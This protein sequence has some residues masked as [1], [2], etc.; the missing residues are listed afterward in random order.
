[1]STTLKI[2]FTL[3]S[4]KQEIRRF[5]TNEKEILPALI[6]FLDSTYSKFYVPPLRF[7][8]QYDD[9][10]DLLTVSSEMELQE[11]LAL[12][13]AQ[14]GGSVWKLLCRF[15]DAP[16][17]TVGSTIGS[18]RLSELSGMSTP[19]V[20]TILA[21]STE[22]PPSPSQMVGIQRED[23]GVSVK[24]EDKP[25]ES[26]SDSEDEYV[27]IEDDAPPS[28]GTPPVMVP[29]PVAS[30]SVQ[31]ATTEVVSTPTD[32][33]TSTEA[34][35]STKSQQ[36]EEV[37]VFDSHI[38]Q[39]AP[40]RFACRLCPK[41]FKGRNFVVEHLKNK[42][43]DVV[44]PTKS[45]AT[46]TET[47]SSSEFATQ[48]LV[49]IQGT[50]STQTES[51]LTLVESTQT[52]VALVEST[53]TQTPI[54]EESTPTSRP[55]E[56]SDVTG[57]H[58]HAD[59]ESSPEPSTISEPQVPSGSSSAAVHQGIACDGCGMSPIVG[60]RYHC[61]TCVM[62]GGYD[63]CESCENLGDKHPLEHVLL[64]M[65]TPANVPVGT[66][67]RHLHT[68]RHGGNTN[69]PRPRAQFVSDVTLA[70]GLQVHAGETLVKVWS[71]KNVGDEPWP[72]GT[73][74]VFAGG[75]LA[76]ESEGITDSVGAAVPYAGAGETVHISLSIVVPNEPGRFRG[77]FRLEAPDRTRFGPRIW[78]DLV[79]PDES[80]SS[81]KEAPVKTSVEES[82]PKQSE[83]APAVVAPVTVPVSAS[84]PPAAT[85]VASAPVM[86]AT[87]EEKPKVVA[88]T[89]QYS[90][91]L[92]TLRSMG[93]K[94]PELCR[95]L[96]LNNQGDLQKVV[97]WLL[98]NAH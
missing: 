51:A 13:N 90:N 39:R 32:A 82:T 2:Y 11:G 59:V 12:H 33:A 20:N 86:E 62:P 10:E 15:D 74:I 81:E 14:G 42:H 19:S 49:T 78:I 35:T 72:I 54:V 70:D 4:N 79:V 50:N 16:V 7:L 93:F 43:A 18:P 52:T 75:D 98:A 48:T 38:E 84:A 58:Q 47:Q 64:K 1:M 77:T 24:V 87:P 55:V 8:I 44:A 63:L 29:T 37:D 34:P 89:F 97:Q 17:S 26:S 80:S 45:T 5:T 67:Q 57:H 28:A 21:N 65:R 40:E 9:G 85:P 61:T 92:A 69:G 3:P 91:Q 25:A 71:I 83:L 27:R 30:T 73:R 31:V 46:S 56:I 76:P 6:S 88:P 95:Y 60:N 22:F 41:L 23:S 53:Q 66:A 68:R 36:T 96:L 94:D